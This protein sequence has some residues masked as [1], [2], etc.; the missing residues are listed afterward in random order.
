MAVTYLSH[1][2]SSKDFT[3]GPFGEMCVQKCLGTL[4]VCQTSRVII[5]AMVCMPTLLTSYLSTHHA[6]SREPRK[7]QFTIAFGAKIPLGASQTRVRQEALFLLAVGTGWRRNPSPQRF[8]PSSLR[9][10]ILAPDAKAEFITLKTT[11]LCLLFA[12]VGCYKALKVT[13]L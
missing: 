2:T 10:A 11:A 13:R 6:R 1:S 7:I 12:H 4:R 5:P 8:K 9:R 3:A